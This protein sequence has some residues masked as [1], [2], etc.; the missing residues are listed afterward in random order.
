MSKVHP[1]SFCMGPPKG[2]ECQVKL[3][4][5]HKSMHYTDA[6]LT[7]FHYHSLFFWFQILF[8][9]ILFTLCPEVLS[10]DVKQRAKIMKT[11]QEILPVDKPTWT[12]SIIAICMYLHEWW[13]WN[14]FFSRN[15]FISVCMHE[16]KLFFSSAYFTCHSLSS[17]SLSSLIVPN[18]TLK[19]IQNS[20]PPITQQQHLCM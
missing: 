10:E 6:L 14:D 8:E 5:Q 2:Y 11:E 9:L 3:P 12:F 7:Q 4:K 15:L 20:P 16:T 18:R 17:F 19:A 1:W 13:L